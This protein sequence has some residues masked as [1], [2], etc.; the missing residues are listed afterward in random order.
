[1]NATF[2]RAAAVPRGQAA[3]PGRRQ[4]R[5]VEATPIDL[6]GPAGLIGLIGLVG[7]R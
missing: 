4:G 6:V 1:M 2:A 3:I 7:S 5:F